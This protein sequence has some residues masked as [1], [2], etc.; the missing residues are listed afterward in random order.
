MR[1]EIRFGADGSLKSCEAFAGNA[2]LLKGFVEAIE[3]AAASQEFEVGLANDD[4]VRSRVVVQF[5]VPFFEE[6]SADFLEVVAMHDLKDLVTNA[7]TVATPAN[8]GKHEPI[9]RTPLGVCAI[10][11]GQATA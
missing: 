7:L 9:K 11:L 8:G 6:M 1:N 5:L 10:K 3:I 4:I 2:A